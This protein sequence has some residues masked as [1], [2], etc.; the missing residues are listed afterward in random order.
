MCRV[1]EFR[2]IGWVRRM[3]GLDICVTLWFP[4]CTRFFVLPVCLEISCVHILEAGM[5]G[6]LEVSGRAHY[7]E[8]QF[9]RYVFLGL[10]IS[11]FRVWVLRKVC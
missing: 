1:I 9:F 5:G 11:D 4:V 2:G 10:K 3:G 8:D 6:G 7:S